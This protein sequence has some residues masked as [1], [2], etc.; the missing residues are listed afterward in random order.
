MF[1]GLIEAIGTVISMHIHE[2]AGILLIRLSTPF[3]DLLIGES[4]AV[5]GVCLTVTACNA[6]DLTF[7][8]SM[9]TLKVTQLGMLMPDDRVNLERALQLSARLGGHFVTGHID[10]TAVISAKMQKDDYC[11]LTVDGFEATA[12]RYLLTKGSITLNGV[13]LTINEVSPAAIQVMLIPH[14][15]THTTFAFC[16]VGD[17]V[18]VEFDYLTR[19]IAH[20]LGI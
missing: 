15:L 7:S 1:T 11:V 5:N 12:Q 16:S 4:I 14:T 3:H 2:D 17:R 6:C 20:Q 9:E 8:V 13:S 10:T 19:I 18:N